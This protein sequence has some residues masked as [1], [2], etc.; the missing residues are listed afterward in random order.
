MGLRFKYAGV[1]AWVE[2]DLATAVDRAVDDTP[3]GGTVQV[4]PTYT[5]MLE[6]LDVLLPGVSRSEAWS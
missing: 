5:A 2:P 4:V 1:D 6:L 3:E